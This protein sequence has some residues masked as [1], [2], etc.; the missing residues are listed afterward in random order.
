MKIKFN[1]HFVLIVTLGIIVGLSVFSYLQ[2]TRVGALIF[3]NDTPPNTE[4][5]SFGQNIGP[6]ESPSE[7]KGSTEGA[8][9][10]YNKGENTGTGYGRGNGDLASVSE[11][12][13]INSEGN[14]SQGTGQSEVM[15]SVYSQG[16]NEGVQPWIGKGQSESGVSEG[17]STSEGRSEGSG[18]SYG[19]NKG[20][21]ATAPQ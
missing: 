9:Y 19:I 17:V 21:G 2:A 13:T 4:G 7:N 6:G 8:S 1:T 5:A 14:K 10:G 18:T 15:D 11:S 3:N 12:T 16:L 20:E